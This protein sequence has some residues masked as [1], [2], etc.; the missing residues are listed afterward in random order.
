MGDDTFKRAWLRRVSMLRRAAEHGPRLAAIRILNYT[1]N[2]LVAHIP[3]FSLRRLW[4]T[5]VLGIRL[6]PGA[7]IHLGCYV[8]FYGPSQIRRDGIEIGAYTRVNRDCTLDTRGGLY[9]GESVS[10]SPEVMI[11]T[12]EHRLTDAR[13]V[14]ESR[15]PV[16]IGDHV[17]IGARAVILPGVSLGRG[18]VVAAGSVVTK[19][20]DELV[21]VGGVPAKPI[22]TRPDH[23]TAYTLDV[24]FPMLE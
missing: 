24:P 7:G 17:F 23:A 21:I 11:L 20:V 4:L 2:H 1:T 13:F 12:A 10:I 5:R 15:A 6:G 9:I 16:A 3:S 8:W 14:E 18:A 19:S 22:G